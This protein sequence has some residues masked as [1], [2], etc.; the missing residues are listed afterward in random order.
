MSRV[1]SSASGFKINCRQTVR[2]IF[3][4]TLFIMLML[5]F[6]VVPLAGSAQQKAS[7]NTY[8]NL[9]VLFEEWREFENP[10]LFEGAPDYTAKTTARR[11]QELKTYQSRLMSFDIENWPVGQQVDWHLVRAEMNGMDFNIRVLKPWVRDPAYYTSVWTDQSDTPAHEG[12]MHHAPVEL[13]TYEFPL[14]P[15]T[16]AKLAAE[17]GTIAPLLHQ[18]K[19]NLTGNARE[20][21]VAGIQNLRDQEVALDELA[22]KTDVSGGEFRD[23]LKSAQ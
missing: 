17:L 2:F 1:A 6:A 23:A 20:L 15:I 19:T 3:A 18:A 8:E 21:W 9:L 4:K 10:P 7:A 16:R 12:P 13:W 5:A 14:D 22:A 11:H